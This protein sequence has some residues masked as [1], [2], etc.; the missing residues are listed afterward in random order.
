MDGSDR[1]IADRITAA[2]AELSTTSSLEE[3]ADAVARATLVSIPG[4]EHVGVSIR[5]RDGRIETVAGTDQ[6]VWDL[7]A[8]QYELNEGPCVRAIDDEPAV[9]VVDHARRDQRWPRF[10]PVAL[11]RGVRS[12]LAVQL[13]VEKGGMGGLNLYSTSSD[14]ISEDAVHAAELFATHAAIALGHAR[15]TDQLN[16][17]LISRKTIGQALGILMERYHLDEDRAFQFMVRV[18]ST[19]NIKLRDVAQEIV[20][21]TEDEYRR[22]RPRGGRNTPVT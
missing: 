13:P 7:D 9:V 4:F 3:T 19:G 8:A 22:S 17:A 12:Q 14:E 10:L 20:S 5:H 6:L 1:T 11:K 18:S 16:Q 21:T 2:A 15:Q